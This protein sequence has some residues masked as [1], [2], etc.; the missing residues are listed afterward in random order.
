MENSRLRPTSS[1]INII[2]IFLIIRGTSSI[3]VT[4]VLL[5]SA[6]QYVI[7]GDP[8]LLA[9]RYIA[10]QTEVVT[11]VEWEKDGVL[12]YLWTL[13]NPPEAKDVLEGKADLTVTTPSQLQITEVDMA[14]QGKYTC[15]VRTNGKTAQNEMFLMVIVDA[16]KEDAWKT[17]TDMV[18]CIET[19]NMHCIGIFPKPSP[20]CGVYSEKTGK[21]LNSVPFDSVNKLLNGTFEVSFN[22][23]F[24][25]QD[26]INNTDISFRCYM[27]YLGT[28]WRSGI[29]HKMFG[30]AGC[31]D[32]PPIVLNGFYNM[33][34]EFKSC[35]GF[36][37]EGSKVEYSCKEGF[38]VEVYV[39]TGGKWTPEG[40]T[41]SDEDYLK[42]ICG[43][44][45]FGLMIGYECPW[46]VEVMVYLALFLTMYLT[47]DTLTI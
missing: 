18:N 4:E 10:E 17:N 36:P 23:R 21:Y 44:I 47:Y 16:C 25:I 41:I 43:D 13:D 19:V 42:T 39:C 24:V 27:M 11:E 5:V 1:W 20:A 7:Q 9:C 12:V 37:S 46:G 3:T 40:S 22:R 32:K 45:N 31:T 29:Q 26:W 30:D 34:V 2:F 8:A 28:P 33:T 15:R 14:M 38:T 35:W 6:H